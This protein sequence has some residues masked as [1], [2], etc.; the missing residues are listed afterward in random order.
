MEVCPEYVVLQSAFQLAHE[1]AGQRLPDLPKNACEEY[2]TIVSLAVSE[3]CCG[4]QNDLDDEESLSWK[5][6]LHSLLL[7]SLVKKKYQEAEPKPVVHQIP[8][9]TS[10]DLLSAGLPTFSCHLYFHVIQRCNMVP[11][12]LQS[13]KYLPQQTASMIF[14]DLLTHCQDPPV[15]ELD[16]ETITMVTESF[17]ARCLLVPEEKNSGLEE[18]LLPLSTQRKYICTIYPESPDTHEKGQGQNKNLNDHFWRGGTSFFDD[19]IEQHPELIESVM[20]HMEGDLN[21]TL[22]L[23]REN[24]CSITVGRVGILC[25]LLAFESNQKEIE[26]WMAH[27]LFG[28]ATYLPH[29]V[30]NSIAVNPRIAK[31]I[32]KI[33][34][35]DKM[36]EFKKRLGEWLSTSRK[37]FENCTVNDMTRANIECK[38]LTSEGP[39]NLS[40]KE[41]GKNITSNGSCSLLTSK[42]DYEHLTDT[43]VVRNDVL[44]RKI[45]ED[46]GGV[47][48]N[49]TQFGADFHEISDASVVY[50]ES[51]SED[52]TLEA[53]LWRIQMSMSQLHAEA[54]IQTLLQ[55]SC[56]QFWLSERLYEVLQNKV[57][58]LNKMGN[59]MK[60][61]DICLYYLQMVDVNQREV[62]GHLKKLLFLAFHGLSSHDQDEFVAEIHSARPYE[63]KQIFQAV[64]K[65]KLT[66]VFNKITADIDETAM[67]DVMGLCLQ[68]PIRIIRFVVSSC[69]ANE[70]QAIHC[71]QVLGY[72]PQT[73]RASYLVFPDISLLTGAIQE[74]LLQDT[75]TDKQQKCFVVFVRELMKLKGKSPL[76]AAEF[77]DSVVLPHISIEN[78]LSPLASVTIAT[79]FALT[80]LMEVMQSRSAIFR[81]LDHLGAQI[82]QGKEVN[83]DYVEVVAVVCIFAALLQECTFIWDNDFEAGGDL[84]LDT[85]VVETG[86]RKLAVKEKVISI[87][88]LLGKN[89]S[90]GKCTISE[91]EADWLM[92]TLTDTHWTVKLRVAEMLSN[93]GHG[94]HYVSMVD[95]SFEL[96]S[97]PLDLLTACALVSVDASLHTRTLE[98]LLDIHTPSG[99]EDWIGALIQILPNLSSTEAH[100]VFQLLSQFI[101]RSEGLEWTYRVSSTL[102][103][104]GLDL[105]ALQSVLYTSQLLSDTL[106]TMALTLTP[107][108]LT[109]TIIQHVTQAY[110]SYIKH[111]CTSLQG[112]ASQELFCLCEIF[113]QVM[114]VTLNLMSEVKSQPLVLLMHIV[115][116]FKE[117]TKATGDGGAKN[118]MKQ[119]MVSKSDAMKTLSG[120]NRKL[121]KNLENGML[122]A[123]NGLDNENEEKHMLVKKLQ[124]SHASL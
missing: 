40:L 91:N 35:L 66:Q 59:L 54:C 15:S 105:T 61:V 94:Q 42:V 67:Q 122:A 124:E 33:V 111:S 90:Q 117:V 27:N 72:F 100:S 69:V 106:V 103:L 121:V 101:Q 84:E 57:H 13:L 41:D 89:L 107:D 53:L 96:S 62:T 49:L 31:C 10:Q 64:N 71:A 63:A 109:T 85:V 87:F 16:T 68:D 77:C 115:T 108:T 43:V 79:E 44:K 17:F 78:L 6:K 83:E 37:D 119:S 120:N 39:G 30:H 1:K 98:T 3:I 110:V 23:K 52:V 86:R 74:F 104:P 102:T 73:C 34:T 32:G 18:F 51:W 58:L 48:H 95:Q 97:E 80:L 2:T 24:G 56:L 116:K 36:K 25:M 65:N 60:F 14:T 21:E 5:Q 28:T 9:Y 50:G 46:E 26:N 114:H 22:K 11:L 20:Q 82:N 12:F 45:F 76:R 81:P 88:P 55:P 8:T 4:L 112:S 118:R 38:N 19:Y 123:V 47:F 70:Q 29:E 7:Y 92:T 75:L 93:A 99:Y 113:H